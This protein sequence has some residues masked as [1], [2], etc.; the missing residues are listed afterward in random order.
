M[1]SPSLTSSMVGQTPRGPR[2]D[3]LEPSGQSD[4]PASLSPYAT[5]PP[6]APAGAPLW[7]A[8]RWAAASSSGGDLPQPPVRGDVPPVG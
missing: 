8:S 5:N 7:S 2:L 3:P 6:G 4:A 1:P